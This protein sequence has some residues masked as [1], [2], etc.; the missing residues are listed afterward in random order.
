MKVVG[1]NLVLT[2]GLKATGKRSSTGKTML[3]ASTGGAVAVP[4]GSRQVKVAVNVMVP[5]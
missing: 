3:I 1:D 2:I 4:Y 5:A